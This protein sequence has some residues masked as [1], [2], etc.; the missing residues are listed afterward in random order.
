MIKS[1]SLIGLDLRDALFTRLMQ[2]RCIIV[3]ELDSLRAYVHS[4]HII[5][6]FVIYTSLYR[7]FV[8][9]YFCVI[10]GR[11]STTRRDADT[12]RCQIKRKID[13]S[14]ADNA[15]R[16]V[17][18]ENVIFLQPHPIVMVGELRT[19]YSHRR[20]RRVTQDRGHS[21]WKSQ[22]VHFLARGEIGE[23]KEVRTYISLYRNSIVENGA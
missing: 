23:F 21:D 20:S 15:P 10:F 12:N 9:I 13:L 3:N 1:F 16:M 14:V 2:L 5:W 4:S 7:F 8:W 18:L 17:W 6:S 11:Q 19:I 22:E